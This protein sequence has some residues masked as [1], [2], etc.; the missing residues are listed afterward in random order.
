M[1]QQIKLKAGMRFGRLVTH[2]KSTGSFWLCYCDCGTMKETTASKLWSG[3]IRS[4]G[5]LKRD[6][7][8][9]KM[10]T[11]SGNCTNFKGKNEEE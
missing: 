2:T 6:V 7:N 4:C 3:G 5:C 11:Y 8:S 10:Y 9:E 1:K